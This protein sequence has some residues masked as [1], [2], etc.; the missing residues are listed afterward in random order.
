MQF[1]ETAEKVMQ[2]AVFMALKMNSELLTPEHMLNGL[3]EEDEI[4]VY[5]EGALSGIMVDAVKI[6]K[7]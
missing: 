7:Q 1:N 4:K 5:Y 6:E 2:L 3:D